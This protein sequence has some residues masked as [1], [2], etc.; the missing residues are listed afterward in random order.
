MNF[1]QSWDTVYCSLDRNAQ[2]I[3]HYLFRKCNPSVPTLCYAM[4]CYYAIVHC[5]LDAIAV[6]VTFSASIH[7]TLLEPV[8]VSAQPSPI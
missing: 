5:P 4:P 6:A 2:V 8:S 3:M 1:T 7:V